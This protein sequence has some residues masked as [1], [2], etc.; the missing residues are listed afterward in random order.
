LSDQYAGPADSILEDGRNFLGIVDEVPLEWHRD[1]RIEVSMNGYTGGVRG[2]SWNSDQRVS[3]EKEKT[4][5]EPGEILGKTCASIL[6][7]LREQEANDTDIARA[8]Y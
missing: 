6:Y 4:E 1:T 7:L 8:R 3:S 2:R 5:P